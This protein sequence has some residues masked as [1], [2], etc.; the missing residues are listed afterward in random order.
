[1]FLLK[2]YPELIWFFTRQLSWRSPKS[3]ELY[4]CN[5]PTYSQGAL[6]LRSMSGR[7]TLVASMSRRHV[8]SIYLFKARRLIAVARPKL[9][10]RRSSSTV[11]NQ[12][13][14]SL[15]VLCRQSLEGPRM[16][17]WRAREWSWRFHITLRSLPQNLWNYLNNCARDNML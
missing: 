10:G 16:Q 9:S 13:C 6:S 5:S 17:A 1:M 7:Q 12:V 11:L 4:V 2:F 15:P 14:L 3:F 8:M